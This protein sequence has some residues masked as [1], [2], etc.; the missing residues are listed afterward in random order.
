MQEKDVVSIEYLEDVARIADLVNGYVYKGKRVFQP[1]DVSEVSRSA[2]RIGKKGDKVCAQVI[3]ADV[4]RRLTQGIQVV[5]IALEN[6][7]HIH[8]AMPVRVMNVESANYHIQ[9]RRIANRHRQKKD[10]EGAEFLSGFA[11]KDRLTPTV[12]IVVYLGREPWDGPRT[13]KDMMDLESYPDDMKE[14]IA[15][16][17]IHLLEVRKYEN[18]E[19]FHTDLQQ[20]FGFLQR[21]SDKQ[22]LADYVKEHEEIFTNLSE[23]AYDMISVLSG[24]KELQKLKKEYGEGGQ[25]NMCKAIDDMVRDGKQ[26]GRQEGRREGR[27]EGEQR[28]NR[29]VCILAEQNRMQDILRAARDSAY[30]EKLFL[31]FKL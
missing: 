29:L 11:R 17:P 16:Y 10:I 24:T 27:Q 18:L 12:T 30:Q 8:Y 5:I 25:V 1:E 14:M 31:E 26:E 19:H 22:L 20:V 3:T 28:V 7:S 9:W 21:E 4:V 23:D 6:Q 2:A 13:L 15:D